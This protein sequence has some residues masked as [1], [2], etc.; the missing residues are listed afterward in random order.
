[1]RALVSVFILRSIAHCSHDGETWRPSPAPSYVNTSCCPCAQFSSSAAFWHSYL[2]QG[3][4][5][6]W[7]AVGLCHQSH[8]YLLTQSFTACC[9]R[10]RQRPRSSCVSTCLADPQ[11]EL[12]LTV[13]DGGCFSPS[14]WANPSATR[15]V[16][17]HDEINV[18]LTLYSRFNFKWLLF[19]DPIHYKVT[20]ACDSMREWCDPAARA[21][22]ALHYSLLA[23]THAW[24]VCETMTV[25]T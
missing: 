6:R 16:L 2:S 5:S 18:C 15:Q 4:V 19:S 25:C 12:V 10:I 7:W 14:C 24:A 11:C 23:A 9:L 13:K 1:M 22:H 3:M 20:H 17:L 21:E 8:S